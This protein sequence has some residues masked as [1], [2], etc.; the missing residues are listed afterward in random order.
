[1]KG[2]KDKKDYGRRDDMRLKSFDGSIRNVAEV[3]AAVEGRRMF[4]GAK[5]RLLEPCKDGS[6]K[7]NAL[8]FSFSGGTPARM[9][10]MCM[11]AE[12]LGGQDRLLIGN[13]SAEAAGRILDSLL[14]DGYADI[15]QMEFQK[16]KISV[17]MYKFDGGLSAAP[18]RHGGFDIFTNMFGA[19]GMPQACMADDG[20]G[21]S[22]ELDEL[23]DEE[24]RR[25]IYDSGGFTMAE[26]GAM[27]RGELER[28]YIETMEGF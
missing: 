21:E 27:G 16:P 10:G 4:N 18:Y 15:S 2:R 11:G 9:G 28:R 17:D 26:M 7:P 25:R 14:D 22:D 24:L 20:S 23:D 13:L 1:M 8:V 19:C 5:R 3:T 6:V 12:P